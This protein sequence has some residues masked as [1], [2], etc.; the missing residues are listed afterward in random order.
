MIRTVSSATEATAGFTPYTQNPPFLISHTP[1]FTHPQILLQYPVSSSADQS[2]LFLISCHL[3]L[4]ALR[5]C[6]CSWSHPLQI[7]AHWSLSP[8]PSLC[9]SLAL[10]F[11]QMLLKA[12]PAEKSCRQPHCLLNFW[13]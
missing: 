1:S 9:P 7:K 12:R 5:P 3:P 10:A 13:T 11:S 4:P 6:S 2:P 8:T